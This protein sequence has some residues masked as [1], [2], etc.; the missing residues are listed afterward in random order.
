MATKRTKKA[1]QPE[2]A[3]YHSG[4]LVALPRELQKKVGLAFVHPTEPCTR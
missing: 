2:E 1:S 4:G 3:M